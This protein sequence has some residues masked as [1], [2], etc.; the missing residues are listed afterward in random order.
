[1]LFSYKWLIV[2]KSLGKYNFLYC[3]ASL[4]GPETLHFFSHTKK[5]YLNTQRSN[6]EVNFWSDTDKDIWRW[7]SNVWHTYIKF[8]GFSTM[9]LLLCPKF[10]NF[11][12]RTVFAVF[13]GFGQLKGYIWYSYWR[14]E[15]VL[16]L[17]YCVRASTRIW[18]FGAVVILQTLRNKYPLSEQING[19]TIFKRRF[20]RT[21]NKFRNSNIK[22]WKIAKL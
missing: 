11:L 19:W 7:N 1:M 22:A 9:N 12:W 20:K 17:A 16:S 2:K 6:N 10:Y 3:G 5:F 14:F 21:G 13:L 15:L 18:L 4:W 8:Y